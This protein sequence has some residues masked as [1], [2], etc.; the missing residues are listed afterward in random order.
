MDDTDIC[1]DLSAILILRQP[2]GGESYKEIT[3]HL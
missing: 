2:Y 1:Q 3:S